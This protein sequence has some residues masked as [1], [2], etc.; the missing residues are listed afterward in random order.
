MPG[1]NCSTAPPDQWTISPAAIATKCSAIPA[2]FACTFETFTRPLTNVSSAGCARKLTNRS[3]R[4]EIICPCTTRGRSSGGACCHVSMIG[5][6]VP[7]YLGTGTYLL[8]YI[9]SSVKFL[10][11]ILDY[12]YSIHVTMC[13]VFKA[14]LRRQQQHGGEG[15][16]RRLQRLRDG[17][18]AIPH[19]PSPPR[20]N[21]K[22]SQAKKLSLKI[23]L[24]PGTFLSKN[25]S[26][27][28]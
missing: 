13:P 24:G 25:D 23:N 21:W 5:Y 3:T 14:A 8:T 20:P 15:S 4:C 28:T 18:A 17:P 19:S 22:S 27:R 2:A 11:Y 6:R 16:R 10:C 26:G 9:I 12:L 7:S 1:R